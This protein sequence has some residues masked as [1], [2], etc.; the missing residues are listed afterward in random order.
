M[1][2]KGGAKVD[3]GRQRGRLPRRGAAG[4]GRALRGR[5]APLLLARRL[6]KRCMMLHASV[7][8]VCIKGCWHKDKSQRRQVYVLPGAMQGD[9]TDLC[10]QP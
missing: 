2:P 7:H 10:T 8:E 6:R 3:R 1:P 4:H 5:E 9:A